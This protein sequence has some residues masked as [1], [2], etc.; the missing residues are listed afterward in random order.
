M[1]IFQ[2]KQEELPASQKGIQS[3]I[4]LLNE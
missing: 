2:P 1:N 4:E 3:E